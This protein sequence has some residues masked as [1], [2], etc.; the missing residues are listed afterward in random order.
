MWDP[1]TTLRL[2]FLLCFS[3]L[4]GQ[5]RLSSLTL[6]PFS[7]CL[8]L[9]HH[10]VGEGRVNTLSSISVPN[11]VEDKDLCLC[12]LDTYQTWKPHDSTC[13]EVTSSEHKR[14]NPLSLA[15]F[16]LQLQ[17]CS[18]PL[19]K[20]HESSTRNAIFHLNKISQY[21]TY[22]LRFFFYAAR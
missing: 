8:P 21:L 7:I 19:T 17:F 4:P 18:H 11:A 12:I 9:S 5:R 13:S 2:V 6:L 22:R 10:K 3:P 14:D 16:C 15:Y 1:H 20:L